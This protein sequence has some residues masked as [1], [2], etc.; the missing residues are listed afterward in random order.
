MDDGKTDL[1][2]PP[3]SRSGPGL[4]L[5]GYL[6]WFIFTMARNALPGAGLAWVGLFNLLCGIPV[7]MS[8]DNLAAVI[9]LDED[10]LSRRGLSGRLVTLRWADVA[11]ITL[12]AGR[13]DYREIRLA[14]SGGRLSFTNM[15]SAFWPAARRIVAEAE[16]RAIP[17]KTTL[18]TAHRSW[19]AVEKE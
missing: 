10:G 8:A 5:A 19:F 13:G 12:H 18:G 14:G 3:I 4:L 17:V 16:R 15:R 6:A 7:F 1:V 9:H 2:L 11:T